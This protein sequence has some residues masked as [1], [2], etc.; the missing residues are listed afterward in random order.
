[1]NINDLRTALLNYIVAKQRDENFAVI[2]DDEDKESV[3]LLTLFGVEY[4]QIINKS[5][6][7]RFHAAMA[8]QLLHEK[9]AFN[10][11]CSKEWI[12]KKQKEAEQANQPYMYDD[13]CRNLPAELVID[14]EN[15][16]VVRIKRPENE[17]LFDS[18]VILNQDK[19]STPDFATAIDDMLN[20]ISFVVTD[21]ESRTA[22][23][24]Q[25]YIRQ[26][27]G[28]E[29]KIEYRYTPAMR[30]DSIPTIK[31][32]LMEGFLPE[33]ILNY[34]VSTV[35]TDDKGIFKLEDS[36]K[37]FDADKL[38]KTAQEFNKERLKEINREHLQEMPD[39]ELSRY[40]GFA[41]ADIG[42]LAKLY[43]DRVSTTK[44]LKEKIKPI[45]EA[46]DIPAPLRKKYKQLIA[47][48]KEEPYF[49]NFDAFVDNIKAK[50]GLEEEDLNGVLQIL[51]TNSQ[52]A[53]K[54][55]D[56]YEHLKNY[57]GEIIKK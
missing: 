52:D 24:K 43:L 36:I 48:L 51:L 56:V 23:L 12:E 28:Y 55:A 45:F 1:M 21:E 35:I 19:T 9:K 37:W 30:G 53:P 14:N 33:T 2:I 57:I 3:E 13:A 18:F 46:R 27:L 47:V 22:S 5:Q 41:D 25:E 40:V 7:A 31:S 11:F 42:A 10:C 15:P 32:L 29:K 8:L 39:K 26:E 54:L 34:L 38:S 17:T 16:F 4:S 20:D 49:E 6:N 44:E 50:T